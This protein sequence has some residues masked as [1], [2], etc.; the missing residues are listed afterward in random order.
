MA[1]MRLSEWAQI[2]EVIGMVAV[3]LSLVLVAYSIRQN[4]AALQGATGNLVFERHSELTTHFM[5]DPSLAAIL[6]KMSGPEPGLDPV[7][8]IRWERYQL[9]LLDIWAMAYNRHR[10]DLLGPEQWNAWN[11][12]F[13]QLFREGGERMSYA[14]WEEYTYGFDPDFWAHVKRSLYLE[15]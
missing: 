2:G 10:Q 15:G 1:K 3:V 12:Y 9:N 11:T 13:T 5:T 6:A 8:A 14:M 7:E 4:T